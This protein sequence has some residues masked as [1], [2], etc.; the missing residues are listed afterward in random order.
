MNTLEGYGSSSDGEDGANENIKIRNLAKAVENKPKK[1]ERKLE[2][3]NL[4]PKHIQAALE[5]GDTLQDSDSDDNIVYTKNTSSNASGSAKNLGKARNI[6][7]GYG[8]A[9][10]IPSGAKVAG[11]MAMLPTVAVSGGD[12]AVKP[13]VDLSARSNVGNSARDSELSSATH[14]DGHNS[15]DFDASSYDYASAAA[16]YQQQYMAEHFRKDEGASSS[17]SSSSSSAGARKRSRDVDQAIRA[18]VIAPEGAI[19][20][21]APSAQSWDTEAYNEMRDKQAKRDNIF[22]AMGA[23]GKNL[24]GLGAGPSGQ[25]S[26]LQKSKHHIN[27]LVADMV[28]A[29]QEL[30]EAR[31]TRKSNKSSNRMR[32]GF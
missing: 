26:R 21:T 12:T 20:I 31:A 6:G 17:S 11:L 15:D 27:S 13:P 30:L 7:S 5:R 23:A 29:E 8:P 4:V 3:L 18:G 2:L 25:A 14:D 22:N 10:R 1:G 28:D 16:A 24:K 19:Q 9:S 32:Y